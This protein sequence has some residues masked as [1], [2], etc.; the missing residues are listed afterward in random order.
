MFP[1][2]AKNNLPVD[3]LVILSVSVRGQLGPMTVWLS[4]RPHPRS[5]P[6]HFRVPLNAQGWTQI[7]SAFHE[8]SQEDYVKLDLSRNPVV[9]V[10]G[11]TRLLYIHSQ[12]PG[13]EA[14][15]YDN[16]LE[17][18]RRRPRVEDPMI[19]IYSGK[20]HLSPTPFGQ[21]P[22][23]GWYVCFYRPLTILIYPIALARV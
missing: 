14:I 5:D 13:D 20:A 12:A 7:Y 21:I 3:Q 16:S 9:L 17:T 6:H 19:A 18:Y 10:P 22:I 8:P 11:E 15:V 4:N 2:K 1:V 23:W